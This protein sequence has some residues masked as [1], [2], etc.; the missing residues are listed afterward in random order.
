MQEEIKK[1]DDRMFEIDRLIIEINNECAEEMAKITKGVD[2][3]ILSY[4]QEQEL[5]QAVEKYTSKLAKLIAER[6]ELEEDKKIWQ[7]K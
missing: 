6:E 3:R 2:S 7:G 4:A 1:I 5:Q